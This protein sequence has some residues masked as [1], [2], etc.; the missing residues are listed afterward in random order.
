[1]KMHINENLF[2]TV[3]LIRTNFQICSSCMYTEGSFHFQDIRQIIR[4]IF[5]IF[6]SCCKDHNLLFFSHSITN[7][8]FLTIYFDYNL[9]I[10]TNLF[11]FL[12]LNFLPYIVHLF[13]YYKNT[14]F[15]QNMKIITL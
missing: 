14:K 4:L 5:S 12:Y 11:T 7:G 8:Q 1:M 9:Y 2:Y 6:I 15:R 3:H 10:L 13:L